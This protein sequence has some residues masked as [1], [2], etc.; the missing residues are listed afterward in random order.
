ML[1]RALTA[2]GIQA[3]TILVDP[4]YASV[5]NLKLI[6]RTGRYFI[7]AAKSNR[8]VSPSKATGYVN[9]EDLPWAEDTLRH[10]M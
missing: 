10:S 6:H 3:H 8:K 7:T 5:E 2:K 1:I 4:W 9:L